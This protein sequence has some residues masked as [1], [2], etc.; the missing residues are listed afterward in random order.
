MKHTMCD[1]AN[2]EEELTKESPFKITCTIASR[3]DRTQ[4][5]FCCYE[6]AALA[7]AKSDKE[8]NGYRNVAAL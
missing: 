6:H 7:L 5:V 2:C 8:I 4:R 1:W 3:V